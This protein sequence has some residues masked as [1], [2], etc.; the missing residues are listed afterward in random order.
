[1]DPFIGEIRMFG[2]NFAPRGWALC[3]GQMLGVNQNQALFSLL[4]TTYGGDGNST[5]G[6]PDL[7]GR[8]PVGQ[9][10]GAGL[11]RT[12]L[13]DKAGS[14]NVTLVAAQM[15]THTHAAM[16]STG[17]ADKA[18]PAG[19]VWAS[20]TDNTGALIPAFTPSSPANATMAPQTIGAAGG[21]QPHSNV[22]PY[23]VVTYIIATEGIYPSRG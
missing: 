19:N 16:A 12:Q 3:N 15:P 5:F 4:G 6:V 17:G 7:Q 1:M 22:Q 2:G 21:N 8:V 20:Q 11:S 18:T 14:E 23:L 10:A 13:G 9:G